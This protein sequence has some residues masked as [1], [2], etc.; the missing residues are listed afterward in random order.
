MGR[1]WIRRTVKGPKPIPTTYFGYLPIAY[2][3]NSRKSDV[4]VDT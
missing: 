1:D 2:N 3:S 4:P